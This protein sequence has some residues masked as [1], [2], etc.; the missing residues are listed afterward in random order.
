MKPK[1]VKLLLGILL[2]G[3]LFVRLYRLDALLGF[4]YDQGRDALVI[5]DF[6][7]NGKLFLVGPV[8]GI[9]GIFRGPWYYW[10]IAPFYFLGR[11]NPIWPAIF[12]ALTSVFALYM[13]YKVGLEIGGKAVAILSVF[14]ASFSYYVVSSSRWLSNPTP[15]LLI[16]VL[17]LWAILRFFD[18]KS[19]SVPFI[20]FLAG[21]AIQ[22]GS[23][24]EIFYIPVILIIFYW[25]RRL[26]PSKKVMLFSACIFFLTFLPQIIFDVRHNGVLL[27]AIN[28]FL[29]EEASFK[30]SFWQILTI[31]APYYFNMIATK[32]WINADKAFA[33]FLIVSAYGIYLARKKLLK[34][35]GFRVVLLFALAPLVGMLFFQGNHGNI[36]DYYFTGYYLIFILF[37]SIGLLSLGKSWWGKATLVVFV[38]LFTLFSFKEVGRYLAAD[39]NKPDAISL[40]SQKEAIDWVYKDAGTQN[41]NID[42]YV[43]PVIPY[44]YDYLFEWL[45][46]ERYKKI[47]TSNQVADLYTIYEVDIPHPERLEAWLTRQE[48]IGK[49]I[50]QER[51]GGIVVQRRQRI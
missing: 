35:K 36:F 44:A 50:S 47:P 13:L 43:P 16:S 6:W 4:W 30:L 2:V 46:S 7:H 22:F 26:L 15:M 19:W 23:A 3:A 17:T 8:T 12:L 29:F 32:F 27:G 42:V 37:F 14:I 34:N 45:G 41:F 25:Q 11:G 48:K 33:P 24:A 40:A 28:K 9:E 38:A 39:I 5:W 1:G 18:R 10:L 21:M 51:F 49:I 20:A 31:R